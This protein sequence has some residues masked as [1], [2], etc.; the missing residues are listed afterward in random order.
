MG[1]TL[2]ALGDAYQEQSLLASLFVVHGDVH[3]G[4]RIVLTIFQLKAAVFIPYTCRSYAASSAV[5]MVMKKNPVFLGSCSLCTRKG[6]TYSWL[7]HA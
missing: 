3:M 1:T 6:C 7:S 4:G 5:V 2:R